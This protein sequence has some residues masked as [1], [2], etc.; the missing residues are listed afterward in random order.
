MARMLCMAG[1]TLSGSCAHVQD[2][3]KSPGENG[4]MKRATRSAI[5]TTTFF[6][7]SIGF[8]GYAAFGNGAP[9]NLISG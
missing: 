2:T 4:N 1:G 6:Y 9:G 5:T 8:I 7:A 3:L